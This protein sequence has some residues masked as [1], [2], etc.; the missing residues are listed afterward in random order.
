MPT[1]RVNAR[2][3]GLGVGVATAI[4]MLVTEPFMAI[5]WDEGYTLGREARLRQW[6]RGLADPA[7]FAAEWQPLPLD[8]ELVQLKGSR[9]PQRSP[10][11][12]AVRIC[13][14]IATYL[15]G[16]GHSRARNRMAIRRSMPCWG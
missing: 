4:L 14:S 15:R 10:A 9:P 5:G 2:L 3:A 13:S 1:P 11:R 16:S 7:A 6:F 12:R 8:L